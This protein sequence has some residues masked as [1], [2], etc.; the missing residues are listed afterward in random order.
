M[1]RVSILGSVLVALLVGLVA[2]SA[3]A[4]EGTPIVGGAQT[5]DA[6]PTAGGVT[7]GVLAVAPPAPGQALTLRRLVLAPGASLPL[8]TNPGTTA[9]YVDA[10]A[11]GVTALT[12]VAEVTRVQTPGTPG[13]LPP[14]TPG[15]DATPPA[16]AV[17]E[18]AAL[19]LGAETVLGAWRRGGLRA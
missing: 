15:A 17:V 5:Q 3:G 18:T 8:H 14:A 13:A 11:L 19:V 2:V 4:Q 7:L 6:T 9:L 10:G 12:G 1:R 16:A